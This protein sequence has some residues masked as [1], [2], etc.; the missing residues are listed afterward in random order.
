MLFTTRH[1][2]V[3][4]SSTAYLETLILHSRLSFHFLTSVLYIPSFMFLTSVFPSSSYSFNSSFQLLTSSV[5]HSFRAVP[6]SIPHSSYVLNSVPHSKVPLHRFCLT[7]FRSNRIKSRLKHLRFYVIVT[8]DHD[9]HQ[10]AC[11]YDAPVSM[12]WFPTRSKNQSFPNIGL[13]VDG[14]DTIR[15]SFTDLK[16]QTFFSVVYVTSW[17]L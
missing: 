3:P 2:Y 16:I 17:L 15:A 13:V 6:T 11:V 9:M 12:V 10:T 4:C 8:E 5:P 7:R 14:T 1:F